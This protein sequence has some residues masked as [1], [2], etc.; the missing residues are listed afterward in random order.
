LSRLYSI[1]LLNGISQLPPAEWDALSRDVLSSHAWLRTV[2]QTYR[3]KLEH[4]YFTLRDHGKL[5]GA[6]ACHVS[7]AQRAVHDLDSQAWGRRRRVARVAGLSFLPALVCG[8]V[9]AWGQHLLLDVCDDEERATVARQLLAAIEELARTRELCVG[10]PEVADNER[11]LGKT[12]A[13]R[14]YLETL[15]APQATMDIRWSDFAGYRQHLKEVRGSSGLARKEMNRF[16]KR[17]LTVSRIRGA[18]EL[19]PR[20]HELLTDNFRAHNRL[21]YPYGVSFL[22]TVLRNLG[23]RALIL[24]ANKGGVPVGV[25]LSLCDDRVGH[26]MSTGVD[27]QRTRGDHV[28]FNLAYYQPIAEATAR[29]LERLCFGR[30]MYEVKRRRGCRFER[31]RLFLKPRRGLMAAAQRGALALSERRMRRL[32]GRSGTEPDRSSPI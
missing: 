17:G 15:S 4:C 19:D 1:E 27:H 32:F 14:G 13:A 20:L 3:G 7:S 18:E 5:V 23:E 29:G 12:L 21:P 22:P 30:M 6:A 31:S 9:G 11:A 8:P 16:R 25:N 26:M 2:E 24:V 10:F 28:Y